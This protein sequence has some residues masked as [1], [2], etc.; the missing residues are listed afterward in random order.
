MLARADAL[1]EQALGITRVLAPPTKR[2]PTS[3]RVTWPTTSK[4]LNLVGCAGR[5]S[6]A[7]SHLGAADA[8]AG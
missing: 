1:G 3:R 4:V 5:Y 6:K 8:P 2:P 7:S